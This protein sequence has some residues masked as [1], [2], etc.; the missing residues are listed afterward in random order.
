M[1]QGMS[2]STRINFKIIPQ[3]HDTIYENDFLHTAIG[4]Q[5][6]F[7]NCQSEALFSVQYYLLIVI[8]LKQFP[9]FKVDLFFK[10]IKYT[11]IQVWHCGKHLAGYGQTISFKGQHVDKIRITFKKSGDE[12][13]VDSLCDERYTI[14][15]YFLN[16]SI[17]VEPSK[18]LLN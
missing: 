8:A 4:N 12:F 10:C 11:I 17:P 2:P 6:N 9:N 5:G 3:S 13:H 14:T 16:D 15:L 7:Q 1:L 18:Y